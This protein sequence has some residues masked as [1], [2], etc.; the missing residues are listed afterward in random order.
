MLPIIP[1]VIGIGAV[2]AGAA[3]PA[4]RASDRRLRVARAKASARADNRRLGFCVETISAGTDPTAAEE[5]TRATERWHTAGALLADASNEEQCVVAEQV[6]AE[7]MDHVAK[8]CVALGIE[9]PVGT[10]A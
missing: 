4:L 2:V 10:G 3:V 8:A 9:P 1:L 6:T 7:G 5:L